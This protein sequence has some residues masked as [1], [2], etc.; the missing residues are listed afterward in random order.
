MAILSTVP[1]S[2]YPAATGRGVTDIDNALD[3]LRREEARLSEALN[4][5]T[6]QIAAARSAEAA[7]LSDLARF[8]LKAGGEAI[9]GRLD[10]AAREADQ[11]MA[12]RAT[13]QATLAT[14]QAAKLALL[15][16]H[17]KNAETLRNDLE[18]VE[19]RIEALKDQLAARLASDP[20][21]KALVEAEDRAV[22]TA[23]AASKKA[24][25]AEADRAAK[26]KAYEADILFT[27]LWKRGFGTPQYAYGGL[28]RTLDRWVSNLIGYLEAR[29][30]YAML[31]EIPVRLRAHA[32]RVAEEATA[33]AIAVDESEDKALAAIAGEDLAGRARALAEGVTA[34]QDAMAPL[35]TET[36]ALD[37]RAAAFAAGEDDA[38][39]RATE[40]LARSIAG[41]EIRAL[42]LEAERTPSPED[43]RFVERIE[44][45]RAE[46][47]RLEPDAAKA[48]ADLSVVATRRQELLRV[49]QD[50]RSRGWD[51]RGH[52]FDLGDFLTGY[53]A[54]RISYGGLWG[55]I[56]STHRGSNTGWS[57]GWGGGGGFGG[58]FSGGSR[59]GGRIGGGG[60]RT[61]GRIGGG[62][63]FRTGGRIR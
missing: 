4:A 14:T 16:Q 56:E 59:G 58:S 48:R 45:A 1:G 57:G 55:R 22:A 50:I 46:I 52:N 51:N 32:E 60:F 62:G 17:R 21:H 43:E 39:K 7:A 11:A 10:Q 35:E 24:E 36:A 12:A 8:K 3:A 15:E 6:Q 44:R 63:G 53:L 28:T 27:Y 42:K 49:S 41:D 54:G 38:F 47:A 9:S 34:Q 19:D 26:S 25:Q 5:V 30:A 61:G 33:A 23:A 37:A 40:A 31:T 18:A 29:P 20:A 13:E 2:I